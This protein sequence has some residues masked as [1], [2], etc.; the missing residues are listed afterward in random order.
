VFEIVATLAPA[1]VTAGV[2]AVA[3]RA[4]E[5][6]RDDRERRRSAAAVMLPALLR[7]QRRLERRDTSEPLDKWVRTARD[8][9]TVLDEVSLPRPWRHLKRSVRAAVGEATGLAFVDLSPTPA[10]EV[11]SFDDAWLD[12]AGEY[13]RYVT[14]AMVRWRDASTSRAARRIT[15]EDYDTWLRIT[16]RYEHGR[17]VWPE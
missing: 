6:R 4:Q 3:W 16:G 10:R 9:L 13:L 2:G 7:L 14:A 17:G 8:A 15:L 1:T 11:V 5:R 12:F